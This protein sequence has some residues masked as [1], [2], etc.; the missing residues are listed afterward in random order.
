[1]LRSLAVLLA[2]ALLAASPPPAAA[3]SA[4]APAADRVAELAGSWTCRNP[5][6]VL[7][8]AAYRAERGGIAATETNTAGAVTA[9]GVFTPNSSGWSVERTT[10]YG[11]FSGY[12][13]AWTTDPWIVTESQKHGAEIL[14]ARIDDRTLRRT[15][16]ISGRPA[17]AG[18]I[19]AKGDAP[20]DPALC[21]VAD[22]P[23]VVVH[24]MM[25]DTPVAAQQNHVSAT[26]DVL[27][28]LD[29]AGHVVSAT[30]EKSGSV[31]VNDSALAAARGSTYQPALHDCKPA[32]STYLFKVEYNAQ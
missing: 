12:A 19:C 29:A 6:G 5:S 8:T 15:F 30:I 25:P 21:A 17:Y 4:P 14:Y 9:T 20:P 22:V 24:A 28:S 27:V 10:K 23:A 18:E 26:V 2:V 13:P 16:R 7:S 1:V 31:L 32:P 3:P 11:T